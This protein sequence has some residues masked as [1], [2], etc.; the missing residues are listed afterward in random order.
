[1]G[2]VDV[3]LKLITELHRAARKNF[4]RRSVIIKGLN[5]TLQADLVEMIPY[6]RE[7]KNNKY[8]LVVIDVFSKYVW[9]LP[10]K[11]KSAKD[12]SE[13]MQIILNKIKPQ[14]KNIQT[15]L[16]KEFYNST[17]ASLMQKYKLNH[18]STFSAKKA[19][20]VERVNRTLKSAMWKIFSYQ[21]S[22][23]WLEVLP[24]V[25][26]KY[27]SSVHSTI[28]MKPKDVNKKNEQKI[29]QT[30]YNRI[31]KVDLKSIKFKVGDK[32]RLSKE[33]SIFHKG[34]MP[35]WTTEVFTIKEIKLTNPITY[36]L[37][38]QGGEIIKG[39]FYKEELQLARHP[40]IYLV[41]K[42]LRKKGNKLFVKWLGFGSEHNSWISRSDIS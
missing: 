26:E 24:K 14:P 35:N 42:V 23:K 20:I 15:D 6:S 1:M 3:K 33:R 34:Y 18:Y 19:S 2:K 8:I 40:D 11:N 38:D 25:V 28:H 30:A 7:N 10:V 27:N 29:L 32:V 21:G 41:E 37:E 12:V 22:Y 36:H 5:E 4:I 16:G 9:A 31:K 13:A 39:G 17:F